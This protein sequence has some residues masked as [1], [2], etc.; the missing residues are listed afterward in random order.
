MVRVVF[1]TSRF[2]A[3]LLLKT[4]EP[5]SFGITV[6]LKELPDMPEFLAHVADRA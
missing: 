1:Y 5:T 3:L 4:G 6:E 2:L